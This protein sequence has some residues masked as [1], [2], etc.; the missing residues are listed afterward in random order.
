MRT[1]WRV[2]PQSDLTDGDWTA[3]EADTPGGTLPILSVSQTFFESYCLGLIGRKSPGAPRTPNEAVRA[4]AGFYC[5]LQGPDGHWPGDYG[6]PLF[7]LPGPADRISRLFGVPRARGEG[8][9]DSLLEELPGPGRRLGLAHEG[10]VYNVRDCTELCVPQDS[11]FVKAIRTCLI[12]F[13][14][15]FQTVFNQ[16][17]Y[18]E[19]KL[20][21]G[22]P[23]ADPDAR[24][25]REL[26]LSWGG[27]V[28]IPS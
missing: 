13:R 5:K 16:F 3:R 12:Q 10:Q 6:G 1:A 11:R 22:V 23:A 8:R 9:D 20:F 18:S 2:P 14:Y 26:I 28:S 15:S 4:A 21:V 17:L 7:L 19:L 25:A 27:A 24:R